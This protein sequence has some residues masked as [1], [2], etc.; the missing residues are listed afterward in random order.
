MKYSEDRI[1]SLALKIHDKLYLDEDVD[2]SDEDKA[3][4]EIKK[5]ML[6]YF[7]I[8]DKIDEMVKNKI[9][10]LKKQVIPGT[11]EWNILYRKYF[12]EEMRK[13][14]MW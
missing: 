7:Q 2:Y 13:H 8:E 6:E 14:K 12:E 11:D 1:K 10:S 3:L 5:V 9:L 4:A